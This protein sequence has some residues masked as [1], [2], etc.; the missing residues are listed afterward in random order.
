VIVPSASA[1][2]LSPTAST[3]RPT[4][5]LSPPATEETPPTSTIESLSTYE[6]PL[7]PA[8]V[9]RGVISSG[10]SIR[11]AFITENGIQLWDEESNTSIEVAL[12]P[13]LQMAPFSPWYLILLLVYLSPM[14]N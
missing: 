8:L 11:V 10:I 7:D 1:T 13:F 2:V 4:P 12:T 14:A 3:T 9:P 5:T 6:C